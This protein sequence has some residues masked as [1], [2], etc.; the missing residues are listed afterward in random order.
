M[1]LV[2]RCPRCSRPRSALLKAIEAK[3]AETGIASEELMRL[4]LDQDDELLSLS[5][6]RNAARHVA[7]PY[8]S[9]GWAPTE[10]QGGRVVLRKDPETPSGL[11]WFLYYP[12]VLVIALTGRTSIVDLSVTSAGEVQSVET[13]ERYRNHDQGIKNLQMGTVIFLIG[14]VV[15]LV[16][17]SRAEPGGTYVVAWGAMVFGGIQA[18]AG[19]ALALRS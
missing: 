12:V 9:G 18:L 7:L 8:V 1:S 11:P 10:Y 14:L 6:Q 17:Y 4:Y 19:A 15:T 5:D 16:T 3:S 2:Y 13:S